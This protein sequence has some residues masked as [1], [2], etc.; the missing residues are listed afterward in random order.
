MCVCVWP[1]G[2]TQCQQKYWLKGMRGGICA[3]AFGAFASD[4][5]SIQFD[6]IAP[7]S[8]NVPEV[9]WSLPHIIQLTLKAKI[10]LNPS[11]FDKNQQQPIKNGKIHSNLGV[12]GGVCAGT[13]GTCARNALTLRITKLIWAYRNCCDVWCKF[14]TLSKTLKLHNVALVAGKW[15]AQNLCLWFAMFAGVREIL[16]PNP[17]C[18][19][20]CST[21]G[22]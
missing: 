4:A 13:S 22:F 2:K 16:C 18:F 19:C 9:P 3:G 20:I 21:T 8:R 7:S 15:C 11:Q 1:R 5:S 12:R 6:N 10:W 17:D 14:Q